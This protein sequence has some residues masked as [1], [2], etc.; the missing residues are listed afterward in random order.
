M[1]S[2][3]KTVDNILRA[4]I[5]IKQLKK[6]FRYGDSAAMALIELVDRDENAK[7]QDVPVKKTE[8]EK[9]SPK[10]A[11]SSTTK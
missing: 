7:N 10:D 1:S 8:Q 2:I 6:G 11:V 9:T 4:K 3:N 5:S